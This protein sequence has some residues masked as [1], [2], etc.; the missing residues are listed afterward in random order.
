MVGTLMYL[1]ILVR[2]HSGL[3]L[4]VLKGR[5]RTFTDANVLNCYR[6]LQKIY[7]D[8]VEIPYILDHL[9]LVQSRTIT[10]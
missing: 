7:V 8:T 6:R 10:F 9:L 5:L 2:S 1:H 3:L 4:R